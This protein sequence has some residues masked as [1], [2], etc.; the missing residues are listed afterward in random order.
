MANNNWSVAS[1]VRK[2]ITFGKSKITFKDVS[3]AGGSL[4]IGFFLFRFFP[5]DQMPLA[6]LAI[7]I[8]AAFTFYLLLRPADNPERRNYELFMIWQFDANR[9]KRK[10]HYRAFK[11]EDLEK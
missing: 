7:L 10:K 9:H 8:L 4:I 6:V 3:V 2:Q 5:A 11:L 1:K